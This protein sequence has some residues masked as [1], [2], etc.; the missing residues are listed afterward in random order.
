MRFHS[1]NLGTACLP[2]TVWYSLLLQVGQRESSNQYRNL[3]FAQ[4]ATFT[5]FCVGKHHK[6]RARNHPAFITRLCGCVKLC[7]DTLLL[8]VYFRSG[9]SLRLTMP[10]DN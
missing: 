4:C 7:K 8:P 1:V 5:I 6:L 10:P 3:K 9:G 2:C